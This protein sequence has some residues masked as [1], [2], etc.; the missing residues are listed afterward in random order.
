MV[1]LQIT[2]NGSIVCRAG[3]ENATILSIH[4]HAW[5]GGDAPAQLD[6]TGM[7]E[8][9]QGRSA[10][11]YWDTCVGLHNLDD[12]VV[13]FTQ[14]DSPS[15][16]LM[17]K[18]I[19]SPEYL[20]EQRQFEEFERTFRGPMEKIEVRFPTVAFD[21]TRGGQTIA[22]AALRDGEEHILCTATWDRWRPDAC[23]VYVRSFGG[24]TGTD[25]ETDWYRGELAEGEHIGVRVV[26]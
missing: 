4:L 13:A 7:C 17:L 1:G 19:D 23:R 25:D 22:R 18:P 6:V 9:P 12:V 20:E 3:I 5:I 21:L 15:L 11:V 10:H 2:R 26:A 8:L 24:S 14:F 16:P